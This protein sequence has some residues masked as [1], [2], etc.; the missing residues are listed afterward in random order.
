MEL[1]HLMML[2]ARFKVTVFLSISIKL[3]SIKGYVFNDIM[4]SSAMHINDKIIKFILCDSEIVLRC[5]L[6][7][8]IISSII[9]KEK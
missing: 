1:P 5:H 4:V 3:V 9:I 6:A 8:F 2:K 7:S